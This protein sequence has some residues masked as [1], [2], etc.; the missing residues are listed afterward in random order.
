M[1]LKIHLTQMNIFIV[2][3]FL[4]VIQKKWYFFSSSC[5]LSCN[6]VYAVLFR[7]RMDDYK[8]VDYALHGNELLVINLYLLSSQVIGHSMGRERKLEQGTG[9][10]ISYCTCRLPSHF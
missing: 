7:R 6:M 9:R 1:Y 10:I 3:A 4:F 2:H 8:D 5:N